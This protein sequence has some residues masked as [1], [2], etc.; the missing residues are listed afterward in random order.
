MCVSKRAVDRRLTC[1]ALEYSFAF[2]FQAIRDSR[3]FEFE[4][5]DLGQLHIATMNSC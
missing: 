2:Q 4:K 1:A 3:G 5:E